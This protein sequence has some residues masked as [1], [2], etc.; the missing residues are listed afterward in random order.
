MPLIIQKGSLTFL[1]EACIIKIHL[2][3][4]YGDTYEK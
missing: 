2:L 4:E 3:N 1:K